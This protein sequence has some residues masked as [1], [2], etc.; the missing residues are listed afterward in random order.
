[1][2]RKLASSL[3]IYRK[4]L[5]V[6]KDTERNA[7]GLDKRGVYIRRYFTGIAED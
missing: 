5:Q 7:Q 2:I 1:M 3:A 6:K 4:E